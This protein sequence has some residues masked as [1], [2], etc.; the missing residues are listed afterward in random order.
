MLVGLGSKRV[1]WGEDHTA[2]IPVPVQSRRNPAEGGAMRGAKPSVLACPYPLIPSLALTA[3]T[4]DTY[5]ELMDEA[6]GSGVAANETLAGEPGRGSDALLIF[7]AT[8][9][10]ILLILI[11]AHRIRPDWFGLRPAGP[12][13]PIG[14]GGLRVAGLASG[15]ASGSSSGSA[16]GPVF[17][18]RPDSSALGSSAPRIEVPRAPSV[19]SLPS[20]IFADGVGSVVHVTAR[21]AEA[22]AGGNAGRFRPWDF[23]SEEIV[24][25]TGSGLIWDTKGHI[26]TC[27]HVL[28]DATR[29]YVTLSDGTV[30]DAKLVGMSDQHDLAVLRVDAPP[31]SLLPIRMGTSD[32]LA[33][34]M[35]VFSLACPYGL[36]PSLSIGTIS[37]LDRNIRSTSGVLLEGTIQTDVGLHA[38]SSGGAL[39]DDQG[40][41]V[42]M[43]AAI[44]LG[45]KRRAG[46]GFAQPI[47]RIQEIVPKLIANGYGWSPRF[48]FLVMGD[49][50]SAILLGDLHRPAA[51]PAQGVVVAEV[52]QGTSAERAK[53]RAMRTGQTP[54]GLVGHIVRDIIVAAEGRPVAGQRQLFEAIE[55]LPDL[56]PLHLTV[57]RPGGPVEVVLL[58]PE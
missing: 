14:P 2:A 42:A 29:A 28:E 51:V 16:L 20:R 26:V 4:P 18:P 34:G 12:G 21:T 3:A 6:Q 37:G 53:L 47:Q 8:A 9:S 33:V 11:G 41:V 57:A 58:P 7:F 24:L 10:V 55:S 43:I 52:F 30:F 35:E 25:G 56:A 44:Y 45:S 19:A 46:V 49:G 39:I 22:D 27:R 13:E 5:C 32:D 15:P 40:R 23:G 36:G 50:D 31:E 17:A 1:P 48:G 38:G 54:E